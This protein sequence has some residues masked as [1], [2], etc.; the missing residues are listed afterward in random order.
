[1]VQGSHPDGGVD[2]RCSSRT[3]LCQT[4]Q[5]SVL[6]DPEMR[7][8]LLIV[9]PVLGEETL[10]MLFVENDDVVEQ[11]APNG[12]R[13]ALGDPVL[14]RTLRSHAAPK[15]RFQVARTERRSDG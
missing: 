9:G 2:G 13:Q 11:L 7:V 12:T 15:R 1:M 6:A 8:V 5:R 10:Q 14:P 4:K 3:S